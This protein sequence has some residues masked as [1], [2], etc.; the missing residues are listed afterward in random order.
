MV[1]CQPEFTSHGDAGPANHCLAS[2]L[3]FRSSNLSANS[4]VHAVEVTSENYVNFS[5]GRI[6][7]INPD[8]EEGDSVGKLGHR[9]RLGNFAS[10]NEKTA[11]FR[12]G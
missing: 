7:A 9:D 8:E 2:L 3:V 6:R 12:E 1:I 10:P 5:F 11:R 4:H